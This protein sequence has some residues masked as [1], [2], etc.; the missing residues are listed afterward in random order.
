[1]EIEADLS[2]GIPSFEVVGLPDA[3]V[4]ESRDRIR[5]S[6][7]NSDYEFPL[8][9][10]TVNM[11]PADKKKEGSL[12][13]LPLCVALLT[14]SGQLREPDP[15]FLFLG[16][17]SLSGDVRPVRGVLPMVLKAREDGFRAAFVPADNAREGAVVSGIDVFPVHSVRELTGH[18]TGAKPLS[19]ARPNF[20]DDPPAVPLPDFSDVR[21]QEEA[22]RALEIAAAGGHN[23]M[24]IGSPGA[25]KSMLAK[26]LPS[27]L[28]DMSFEEMVETTKIHSVA[29]T[30]APRRLTRAAEAVP[31]AAP[32][33]LARGPF[34]RRDD[35]RA[36][37]SS[38]SRTTASSFW[39]SFPNSGD[40]PWRCCASRSRTALSPSPA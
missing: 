3:S 11:A 34:R 4:R 30:L 8:A 36:R 6:F 18:L 24:L 28:P 19:P 21:G 27:I 1:M 14:A 16:E 38:R 10:I 7:K 15:G 32:H 35:S 25:G 12:Y 37:A 39:T 29:G 20:S 40:P 31:R 22:K 9:R 2:V 5:S 17:L 23:V 33:H 13:D 26:R